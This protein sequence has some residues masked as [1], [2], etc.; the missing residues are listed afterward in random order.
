MSRREFYQNGNI[1]KK[2]ICVVKI[3]NKNVLSCGKVLNAVQKCKW[4]LSSW[5]LTLKTIICVCV[6]VCVRER[7]KDVCYAGATFIHKHFR[8][9]FKQPHWLGACRLEWLRAELGHPSS[10][11]CIWKTKV[12]TPRC[13]ELAVNADDTAVIASARHSTLFVE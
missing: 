7:D 1:R 10:S 2:K 4:I 6:C 11:A 12:P 3:T 9:L 5:G 13:L 8:G